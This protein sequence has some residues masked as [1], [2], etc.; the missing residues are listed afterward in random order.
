MDRQSLKQETRHLPTS[1][2][3]SQRRN[4]KR[5]SGCAVDGVV[6]CARV[7]VPSWTGT[8]SMRK[9][10]F[11]ALVL[12]GC[13][14]GL[15][16]SMKDDWATRVVLS[17]IGA[18]VGAAVGGALT[19]RSGIKRRPELEGLHSW[20]GNFDGRH[21]SQLL[22][23]Q[24]PPAAHEATIAAAGSAHPRS[25]P[26]GLTTFASAGPSLRRQRPRRTPWHPQLLA[27]RRA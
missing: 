18:L 21:R 4:L 2:L 17:L 15:L 3:A 13:A 5:T 19:H 22:A 20:D 10:V 27:W 1:N 11:L 25:G 23:G 12:L 16:A 9:T 24:G 6:R 14:A 8:T 7:L 26:A